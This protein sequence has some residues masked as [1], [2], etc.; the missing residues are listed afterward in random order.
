MERLIVVA[1]LLAACAKDEPPPGPPVSCPTAEE[2]I[3]GRALNARG[4]QAYAIAA[5]LCVDQKWGQKAIQCLRAAKDMDG[6]DHCYAMHL[7][8]TQRDGLAEGL[9]ALDAPSGSAAP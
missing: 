5:K 7:T 1:C 3:H 4:Q 9:K 8:G 2:F 6:E